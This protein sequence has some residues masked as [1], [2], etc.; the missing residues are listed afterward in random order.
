MATAMTSKIRLCKGINIDR[1][2]V[3]VTD[4][5]EQQMLNLCESNDHLVASANDY[6]FIRNR[7]TISTHFKYDDCLQS[8]YIAFQNKDYSNKW[9]F[10]WIDEVNYIGENNTEIK[11]TIDVWSTWFDYW[12]A[13]TCLVTREHVNDDTIGTNTISEDINIG[14]IIQEGSDESID[15]TGEDYDYYYIIMTT[16]NPSEGTDG[17]F[18]GVNRVNKNLFGSKIYAFYGSS[19]GVTYVRNFIKHTNNKSK[20]ESIQALFIAPRNFNRK[21]RNNTKNRI[22]WSS[23]K[24]ENIF[25]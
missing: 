7:G 19:L 15:L 3:N 10:A 9:F 11:Y 14:E 6:S 25:I 13:K 17:D 2:Y 16:Y 21:Y 22:Y 20:I 24:Q 8:N 18:V 12:T 5:S 1:N 4:Y 23:V